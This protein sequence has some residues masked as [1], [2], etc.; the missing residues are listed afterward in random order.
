MVLDR[1]PTTY[2]TKLTEFEVQATVVADVIKQ[3]KNIKEVMEDKTKLGIQRIPM[4]VAAWRDQMKI[5]IDDCSATIWNQCSQKAAKVQL[6]WADAK[7]RKKVTNST[8]WMKKVLSPSMKN[9]LM[10]LFALAE[11]QIEVVR[12]LIDKLED[13]QLNVQL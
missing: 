5:R 8:K 12:K 7:N 3:R 9:Y 10:I 11:T 6:L 1:V 4:I 13:D 2:Q